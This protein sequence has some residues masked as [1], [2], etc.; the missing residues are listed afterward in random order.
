MTGV[1]TVA[2]YNLYQGASLI[3]AYGA[4]TLA[5][6]AEA[7]RQAYQQM[8]RT[9]FPGRAAAI[10]G[11]LAAHRP[12]VV[13]VQEVA[14]WQHGEQECD[15]LELLLAGLAR[16][17]LPYRAVATAVTST[18]ALHT[19]GE[20]VG[21]T[22]RVVLLVQADPPAG[23][24]TVGATGQQLYTARIELPVPSGLVVTKL[25]GWPW[26][27]VEAGGQP[28]RIVTTHLEAFDADVRL[29]QGREL[30]DALD[31]RGLP[32]VV[33]GDL[34]TGPEDETY[35]LFRK[36]GFHDAWTDAHGDADGHTG[37]QAS[38]LDNDVSRLDQRYD[39][40][41]HRAPGLATASAALVGADAGS[42]LPS[43]LWASDHAGVVATFGR[44]A[45]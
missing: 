41:L 19:G 45:G 9:D 4:E 10:A 31:A 28:L 18:T 16:A 27:E 23:R 40:V 25:R 39:Y 30:V 2:T 35:A 24:L 22:D 44:A 20:V 15:F 6:M 37:L 38:T 33:L 32:A 12:D 5:E 21:M 1:L 3:P 13:G 11:Q 34:N 7:L 43:G 42:R 29:A 14:R 36:C 8:T 17:G 26:A